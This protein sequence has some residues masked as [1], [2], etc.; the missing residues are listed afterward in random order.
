[1]PGDRLLDAFHLLA[2]PHGHAAVAQVVAERLDDLLVREL[3]QPVA[4]FNQ[5]YAHAQ[6]RE[7][8]GVFHADHAAA[9]HDQRLGQRLQAQNLVAVDDGLAVHRHFVRDGGLGAHGDDDL[10][11]LECRIGLRALHAHLVRIDE[12]GDAVH[13]VDAVARQLRLG[14]VHLGLDHGLDA[15]GQVRH[16]DL[17]L[18]PVVHAVDGAVVVAGKVQ[19]R[20]AHGL[21][22]DGAGVDAHAPN[23]RASLN[24]GHALAHL[25][26]G[27]R[28][29][30]PR[31]P[32]TDHDQV[33]LYRAHNESLSWA[34]CSLAAECRDGPALRC[35]AGCISRITVEGDG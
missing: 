29:A 31:W 4:L 18:H 3:Q 13:H 22:G 30:L 7:H 11:G 35:P 28:G 1:M 17:F 9:H 19:H 27:H 2:Q 5:R 25:G 34:E 33:I 23:H 26:S 10:A 32:G 12:A 24:H 16:G 8:A 14:H 20:L 21:G 15:K 6:H